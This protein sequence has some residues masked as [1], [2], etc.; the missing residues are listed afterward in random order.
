MIGI[1][2]IFVFNLMI[3]YICVTIIYFIYIF[4][5]IIIYFFTPKIIK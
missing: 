5:S 2:I 1:Y 3:Y 4:N